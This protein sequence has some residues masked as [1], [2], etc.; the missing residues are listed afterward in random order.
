MSTDRKLEVPVITA[1]QTE[2]DAAKEKARIDEQFNI[3]RT[4]LHHLVSPASRAM[5][6]K[7]LGDIVFREVLVRGMTTYFDCDAKDQVIEMISGSDKEDGSL[8]SEDSVK[9]THRSVCLSDTGHLILIVSMAMLNKSDGKVGP[10][11]SSSVH[12]MDEKLIRE[13]L[14]LNDRVCGRITHALI[15]HCNQQL[16]EARRRE[17]V[18]NRALHDIESGL[19]VVE[20]TAGRFPMPPDG[21]LF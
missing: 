10:I 18:W 19:I 6:G 2:T 4:C 14:S 15:Y 3:I 7:R 12:K 21:L 20:R 16:Q 8:N 13:L 1:V 11:H 5:F 17:G 9:L